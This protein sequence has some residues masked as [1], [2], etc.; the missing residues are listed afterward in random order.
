MLK[1]QGVNN[2]SERTPNEADGAD[3]HEAE[4]R[5]HDGE[6]DDL[7]GSKHHPLRER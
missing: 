1:A 4:L 5:R 3:E 2:E 7:R 6:I